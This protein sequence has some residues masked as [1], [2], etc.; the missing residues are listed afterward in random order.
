[1]CNKVQYDKK[2]ARTALNALM[3]KG[4]MAYGR[5][6]HCRFCKMWHLTSHKKTDSR[7]E[8]VPLVFGDRWR[9]LLNDN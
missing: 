3:E 9:T 8:E 5:I 2:N 7:V 1:M 6:Y 4:N